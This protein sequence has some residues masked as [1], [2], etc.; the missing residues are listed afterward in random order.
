MDYPEKVNIL[1]QSVIQMLQERNNNL[2]E[3]GSEAPGAIW[4][5]AL[6]LFDYIINLSAENF[7]NIRFHAGY[8]TGFNA[9]QYYYLYPPLDAEKYASNS[10]YI[11]YTR[12]IPQD[13]WIGEPPTP[14]IHGPMG[15][16]YKGKIVNHD[17]CRYQS[18]IANLH[19]MGIL[20]SLASNSKGNL[21]LEVGGGYGGLAH[22]LGNILARNS[23]YI[24]IDLPEMLLFSG[25]FLL[26]N[27]PQ[28]RIYIYQKDTFTPE[29]LDSAIYKYDYVLLPNYLLNDLYGLKE[30]NLMLNMQS[31]QEMTKK[32]VE[33][34]I[35][36]GQSKLSGYLYSD[37]I[38]RHPANEE[39]A[40]ET[41]TTLLTRHFDLFPEPKLYS[42]VFGK[43]KPW[44]YKCYIG[45]PKEKGIAFSEGS[46][47]KFMSGPVKYSVVK[48]KGST[49][50][51]SQGIWL[52][53]VIMFGLKV[54]KVV[55]RF[56]NNFL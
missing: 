56:G 22:H 31:F 1:K 50:Y 19:S 18:C 4:A 43:G 52:G 5:E 11:F 10:G 45:A 35:I 40:P 54:L 37:N 30:I 15:I 12:G 28:K 2:Q 55:F 48:T 41:I 3:H 7:L 27:N 20:D 24:I 42:K 36:F 47:I 23:T 17:I 26:V 39:L 38:D 9:L 51:K 32:Q 25:G 29:F 46:G 14:N 33:E 8:I 34:Y 53:R 13:Y 44:F 16:N 49:R 21:I 6:C